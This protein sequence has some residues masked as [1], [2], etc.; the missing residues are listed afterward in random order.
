MDFWKRYYKMD[1]LVKK[2]E[3][4]VRIAFVGKYVDFKVAPYSLLIII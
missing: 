1:A 2:V 4:E 3:K